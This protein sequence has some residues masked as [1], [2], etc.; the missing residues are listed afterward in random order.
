MTD[1][2]TIK[3]MWLIIISKQNRIEFVLDLIAVIGQKR[4]CKS[5]V[6]DI[7]KS[8]ISNLITLSLNVSNE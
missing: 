7:Y 3:S 2:R 6:N 1:S 8:L 5:V 4:Q